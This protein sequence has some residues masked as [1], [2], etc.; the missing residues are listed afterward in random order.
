MAVSLDTLANLLVWWIYPFARVA[1]LVTAAPFYG[2]RGVPAR[3]KLAIAVALSLALAPLVRPDATVEVF[4]LQGFGLVAE[5]TLIGLAL[6]FSLRLVFTALEVGGQQL[7][8]LMG[9]GFASL[10]D[11]QTGVDVPVISHFYTLLATLV[12]LGIDG[13]L[14]VV[15]V[16][17]ESFRVMPVGGA[18]LAAV[19]MRDLAVQAGWVFTAAV[20]IAL[21]ATV[22]LLTVNV[23]FGVMSRAAPQLNILAVGFPVTLV[24]GLFIVVFTLPG[25]IHEL[26]ALFDQGVRE[27]LRLLGG[28][29]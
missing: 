4:S 26:P 2:H 14:V 23:A 9:L 8:Q 29:P 12:F 11:P 16:L 18:G 20:A 28:G 17:A 25:V 10:V 3:V 19:T 22:A 13:H 7:A 5:Q 21:P 27:S 1:G 6:G 24:L 15:E